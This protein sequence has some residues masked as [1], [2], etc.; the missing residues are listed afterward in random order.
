MPV[1]TCDP[2]PID[3]LSEGIGMLDAITDLVGSATDLHCV[4]HTNLATLLNT[5]ALVFQGAL[6]EL[7]A[8][9][10]D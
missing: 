6:D 5:I 9:P 1:R 3:R 4:D 2:T 7:M 10:R 8:V